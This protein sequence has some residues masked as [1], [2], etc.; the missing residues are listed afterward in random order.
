MR[1]GGDWGRWLLRRERVQRCLDG[2]EGYGCLRF[3]PL[4]G[5][6]DEVVRVAPVQWMLRLH[7]LWLERLLRLLRLLW[8]PEQVLHME[9]RLRNNA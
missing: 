4:L 8:L 3:S 7:R 2:N 1:K 9:R 6:A 5:Y